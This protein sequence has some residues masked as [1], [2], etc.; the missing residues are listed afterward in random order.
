MG[1]VRT[2]L[3]FEASAVQVLRRA[4]AVSLGP[5]SPEHLRRALEEPAGEELPATM[6][7]LNQALQKVL[8][9][10]ESVAR[11]R[12]S[13]AIERRDLLE[14]LLVSG[15]ADAL[16]LSLTHLR[17]ARSYFERRSSQPLHRRVGQELQQ[18][19]ASFLKEGSQ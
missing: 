12:T 6:L 10:A 7:R 1:E 2:E 4:A 5:T 19:L 8:E 14:A 13:R 11:G 17:F 15:L 3:R 18:E 9:C 16:G